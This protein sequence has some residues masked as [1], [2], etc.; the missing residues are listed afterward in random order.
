MTLVGM[1]SV[2]AFLTGSSWALVSFVRRL[3]REHAGTGWWVAFVILIV[4]GVSVGIWCAFRCE[5]P[6]GG[7]YRIG[8]FPLPVVFFR[9]EDGKWVD[10]PV[11][12][13]Q[14]WSAAFTNIF[15]ITALATVPLWLLSWRQ[16]RPEDR[17]AQPAAPANAG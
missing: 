14:A 8:S 15:T 9:L 3:R 17:K 6:L 4:I 2:V 11:P 10:F 5:Y 13:F 12:E 1:L 16:H 7:H